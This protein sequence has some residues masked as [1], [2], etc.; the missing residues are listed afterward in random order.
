MI[1]SCILDLHIIDFEF[2]GFSQIMSFSSHIRRQISKLS[3][4][5]QGCCKV[6]KSGGWACSTVV[7]IICPLVE[8]GSTVR[9]K[10]APPAPRLR[11]P[12]YGSCNEIWILHPYS[13]DAEKTF[14]ALDTYWAPILDCDSAVSVQTKTFWKIESPNAISGIHLGGMAKKI[15]FLVT[16]LFCFSR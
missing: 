1:L 11:Q 9:P 8:V 2:H 10:T 13:K 12:W 5:C 6:W 7:G 14:F 16:K 3:S 4:H 15:F